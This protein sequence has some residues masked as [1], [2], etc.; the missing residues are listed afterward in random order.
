MKILIIKLGAI[1]DIVISL[2]LISYIKE[3]YKDSEITWVCGHSIIPL[4]KEIPQIDHIITINTNNLFSGNLFLKFKE[5]IK[6]FIKLKFQSYNI[7]LVAHK[8]QKI[9]LLSYLV[10]AK[11][12][13][14]FSRSKNKRMIPLLERYQPDEHIRLIS[15]IDNYKAIKARFPIINFSLPKNYK[16]LFDKKESI[17]VLCPGRS[18]QQTSTNTL[19]C[20]PFKN[21]LALAD[22][23]LQ[24]GHK[25]IITG[26]KSDK[27]NYKFKEKRNCINLI[28]KLNIK[29]LLGLIQRSSILITHDS[30]S[31]HLGVLARTKIL[32]LY[33]PTRPLKYCKPQKNRI[34]YI[35]GGNN[36]ACRPCSDDWFYGKCEN[37]VCMQNI[38][39]QN[40]YKKVT[41]MLQNKS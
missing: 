24:D 18:F 1:G 36:L 15:G 20:W 21:Y 23:L 28:G 38:S 9:H 22:L 40:V 29:D 37:N 30:G 26:T 4:L 13:L 7:V 19:R 14:F 41:L 32:A 10:R 25:V 11:K 39:Y 31:F 27:L 17:I 8:K 5:L 35:W 3:K 12:R 6:L 33:G 2:G 34:E 16:S